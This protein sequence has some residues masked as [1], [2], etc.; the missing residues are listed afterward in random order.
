MSIH[1]H[2]LLPVGDLRRPRIGR[3]AFGTLL[4][5]AVFFVFTATK[6]IKP[7]YSHAPW[8]S[9]PYATVLS[10]TM[11][12]VPLVA[13][14]CLMQISL[15]RKSEPLPTG[16]VVMLLR[17]CRVAIGAMV[18]ELLSAWVAFAVQANRSEWS[19]GATGVL[20]AIL[21][22]STLVTLKVVLDL[23]RAPRISGPERTNGAEDDWLADVVAVAK[24]E[25]RWLGPLRH[26]ELTFVDWIDRMA[27]TKV[28]RHP[29][30]AAAASG[31]FALTVLGWQSIRES[32]TVLMTLLSI[33]LGFCG[34]FAFLV[35]A[36]SYLEIVRSPNILH[37]WRRRGLDAA[38]VGCV[39]TIAAVAFRDHL[40]WS[41]GTSSSAAG[42]PQLAAL[43]ISATLLALVLAF[44]LET[45]L[46]YH[47]KPA[48]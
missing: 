3:A 4:A 28:R 33:G 41:I 5:A 26:P 9:D 47:S 11:F 24:K 13:A 35:L 37:G 25:S 42:P 1:T 31:V 6:Q 18:A 8:L 12:F 20:L 19:V 22:L 43:L 39:A 40:W 27:V 38:V 14:S 46:G 30:G 34:M 15:C 17:G 45:L 32:Y 44:S 48:T 36:G 23:V 29:I 7:L 10:F 2:Q 21:I 16:R